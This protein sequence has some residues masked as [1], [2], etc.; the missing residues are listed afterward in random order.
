ME[1]VETATERM[2]FQI[3]KIKTMV[4]IENKEI[5]HITKTSNFKYYHIMA[6]KSK[7]F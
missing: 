2:E 7:C 1:D 6:S 4:F 3:D 5:F